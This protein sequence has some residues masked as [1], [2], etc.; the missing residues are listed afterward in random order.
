MNMTR[1]RIVVP[2]ALFLGL[3]TSGAVPAQAATAH[4]ARVVATTSGPELEVDFVERGL[5]PGQNYAYFGSSSGSET[6]QCYKS[7]TFTPLPKTI[8]VPGSTES[9][10]RA[11]QANAQGVV[12]G[13]IFEDLITQIP[14]TFHCG[15]RNELV[16]IHVCYLPYDLIQFAEPSDVYYFP[17][18]TRA[19]GPIEPD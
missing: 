8:T 17:D 14:S 19:C 15:N 6:Y 3:I 9:D 18:G 16:P 2:V 4:F 11:Y 12:K 13:F 10:S 1:T 7:R 5:G